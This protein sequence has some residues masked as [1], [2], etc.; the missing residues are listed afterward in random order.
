MVRHEPQSATNRILRIALL[1][2]QLQLC[3]KAGVAVQGTLVGSKVYLFGGEDAARRP[4]GDLSVLDLADMQWQSPEVTGTHTTHV[5]CTY[6]CVSAPQS[7][8]HREE[9]FQPGM[10]TQ[11]TGWNPLAKNPNHTC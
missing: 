4:Q 9:M 3:S 8:V 2:G 6:L 10:H 11:L 1:R 5:R 7:P